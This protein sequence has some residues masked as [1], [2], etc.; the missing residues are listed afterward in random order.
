MDDNSKI[1]KIIKTTLNEWLDEQNIMNMTFYH[2]TTKDKKENILKNGFISNYYMQ[3]GLYGNGVYFY[4]N[5]DDVQFYNKGGIV[6]I[7]LTTNKNILII[8]DDYNL[9]QKIS[10]YDSDADLYYEENGITYEFGENYIQPFIENNKI[11]ALYI[12]D[13]HI[14]VVFNVK[15]INILK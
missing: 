10:E 8:D 11:N 15:I 5:L 4:D 12:K 1:R 6:E 2:G 9:I 3:Q 13:I 7:N 14:L